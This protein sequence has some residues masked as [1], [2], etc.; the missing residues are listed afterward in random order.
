GGIDQG[1]ALILEALQ[2]GDR[3]A[4]GRQDH[5]V[6]WPE[7]RGIFSGVCQEA[8]AGGAQLVVDVRVVDDFAGQKDPA[9][10]EPLARLIRVVDRTIDAVAEAELTREV[11]R[12]PASDMTKVVGFDLFDQRAV[13]VLREVAG[14]G[15]FEIE[16]FAENQ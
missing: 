7:T 15:I 13:V 3:D 8:D 1:A 4:E 14:D 2:I 6:F 9:V 10:A 12:Q 11:Y 16:T 5:D